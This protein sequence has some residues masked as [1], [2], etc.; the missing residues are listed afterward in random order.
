MSV[1]EDPVDLAVIG[2]IG[3][4]A[5]EVFFTTGLSANLASIFPNSLAC[6]SGDK[7]EIRSASF[8]LD[9]R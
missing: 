3:A 2:A 4:G 9:P 7:R 8:G 1:A 5:L 6:W